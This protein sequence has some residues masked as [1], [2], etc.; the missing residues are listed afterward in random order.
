MTAGFGAFR[1]GIATL[2]VVLGLLVLSPVAGALAGR[3]GPMWPM[4]VGPLF[5]A[6][7]IALMLRI[8]SHHTD[9]L[10]AVLPGVTL[11]A[12]GIG[13]FVAPLTSAV[14]GSAPPGRVGV[15]SGV[16]NAVARAASL[17]AVALIPPMAGLVGTRYLDPDVMTHGF[18]IAMVI[19]I[20]ILVAGA[21]TVP[22]T[23]RGP[24]PTDG[25]LLR[26]AGR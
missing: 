13:T 5:A 9:Y 26:D 11:F 17:L 22:F 12:I 2:P 8:D 23:V 24:H 6:F 4:T 20:A 21:A 7:G 14:M 1:A 19:S 25:P 16:N 3:I 10:T 18:R 15:A